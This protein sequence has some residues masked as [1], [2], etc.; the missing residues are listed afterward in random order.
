[1]VFTSRALGTSFRPSPYCHR[2]W[3]LGVVSFLKAHK[4]IGVFV[5]NPNLRRDA[6]RCDDDKGHPKSMAT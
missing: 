6:T 2:N 4:N 1:V 5:W 3:E